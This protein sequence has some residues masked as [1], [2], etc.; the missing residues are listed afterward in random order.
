M[1]PFKNPPLQDETITRIADE[2]P[3]FPEGVTV[4]EHDTVRFSSMVIRDPMAGDLAPYQRARTAE[5]V[6][7][8]AKEYDNVYFQNT[9]PG[10]A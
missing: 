4:P 1:V 9:N 7:T 5:S 8:I 6:R 10:G 2:L 3:V